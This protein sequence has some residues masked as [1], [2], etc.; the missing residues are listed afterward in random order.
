MQTH[1]DG[2]TTVAGWTELLVAKLA[3]ST[4]DFR[5]NADSRTALAGILPINSIM[6][7][8]SLL[9]LSVL[10]LL[11][12]ACGGSKDSVPSAGSDPNP[13]PST[14]ADLVVE[15]VQGG[16]SFPW[17]LVFAPDGRMFFTE[18]PGRLRVIDAQGNLVSQ[19][20]FEAPSPNTEAGLLGLEIDR[21]F[22]NN[23]RL[24]LF[25]C[26]TQDHCQIVRLVENNNTATIDKKL[27]DLSGG[28][29]HIAGRIRIGPDGFLY[30]GYGDTE[31]REQAQDRSKLAGKI[32]RMTLDGEPAPGNPIPEQPFAYAYGFRD[33]QGLAWT[34]SGQLYAT[35]H[36]WNSHDE[37]DLVEAG[38]NYGWPT[39]EGSCNNPDFVDPVKLF[40]PE[41]AAPSGGVFYTGSA[42]P[43]WRDSLLFGTLGL[44]GND[45]ARHIHR[46]KFGS[47]GR[48]IA[49]EEVLYRGQYGRIRN[50]VQGP[51]GNLY[52]MTSNGGS[53][54]KILRIRPR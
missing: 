5:L 16:L 40:F 12:A 18:R 29:R 19:P 3:G 51:D 10:L 53:S 30:V 39:C 43:Q 34:A 46:I 28:V 31:R 17:E 35:D 1:L 7:T 25:Y 44:D 23:R 45:F 52:F 54:D 9:F 2:L 22:A 49:E 14:P 4:L 21:D 42:I 15:E 6:R 13:Q 38:K 48:Q 36:G 41:T 27:I 20:V 47:D 24:Y 11:L 32:L 26:D 8:K 50:V 33:P 37:V